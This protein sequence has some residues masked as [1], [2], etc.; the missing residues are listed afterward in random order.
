MEDRQSQCYVFRKISFYP[1]V[2]L[3]FTF[4]RLRIYL[5]SEKVSHEWILPHPL[6]SL[7]IAGEERWHKMEIMVG[8]R[9]IKI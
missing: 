4:I 1:L 9:E 3:P 8:S 5:S 6:P 2:S 7:Y